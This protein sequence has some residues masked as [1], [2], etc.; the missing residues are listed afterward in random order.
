MVRFLSYLIILI[1]LT[2]NV[3]ELTQICLSTDGS[4]PVGMDSA[5]EMCS[6][7][8]CCTEKSNVTVCPD[9]D[10]CNYSYCCGNGRCNN[11]DSTALS[12]WTTG[13]LVAITST[14][15]AVLT[16]SI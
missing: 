13:M 8:V 9:I 1:T 5:L 14:I 2:A 12:A 11:N 7:T 6:A 16:K 10:G 3:A 15:M 4:C